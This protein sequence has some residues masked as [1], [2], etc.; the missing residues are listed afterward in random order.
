MV[1]EPALEVIQEM[2]LIEMSSDPT[3][4]VVMLQTPSNIPLHQGGSPG[5]A[6]KTSIL[7]HGVG[8]TTT[9]AHCIAWARERK[10]LCLVHM[11]PER[12]M[13]LSAWAAPAIIN[14][15]PSCF[16]QSAT[17][18]YV[19]QNLLAQQIVRDFLAMHD[20][21][22]LDFPVSTQFS[23]DIFG[24]HATLF[25]ILQH[26]LLD[27][28]EFEQVEES[29]EDN[30][31]KHISPADVAVALRYEIAAQ[32]RVPC[33]IAIDDAQ[34]TLARPSFFFDETEVS[35][36]QLK[37][38]QAYCELDP[39]SLT[40]SETRRPNRGIMLFATD[41]LATPERVVSITDYSEDEMDA[42]LDFLS[43]NGM[44]EDELTQNTRG[45]WRLQTQNNPN[46][47]TSKAFS[48]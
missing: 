37:V 7:P 44:M 28:H 13:D 9:L 2:K 48:F 1:R 15:I 20:R 8:K 34:V 35:F 46:M 21:D 3:S 4:S 11:K 32:D 17:G 24:P 33:L 29:N 41:S 40:V 6:Q 39:E 18:P 27:M 42:V 16:P 25:E 47:V 19:D 22:E 23:K 36:D 12:L 31:K 14:K 43:A 5:F 26:A 38:S 45:V 30:S 10:W